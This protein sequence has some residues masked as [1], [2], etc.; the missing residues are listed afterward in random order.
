MG[1][2]KVP[3]N[4]RIPA[5]DSGRAGIWRIDY[6]GIP[7]ID[8]GRNYC[9]DNQCDK[10][11]KRKNRDAVIQEWMQRSFFM[12]AMRQSLYLYKTLATAAKNILPGL[13]VV[14]YTQMRE[15]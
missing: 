8:C 12:R 3:I 14:W 2:F 10:S 15:K 6:T 11:I 13:W 4:H 5:A 1:D 9:I 7:N